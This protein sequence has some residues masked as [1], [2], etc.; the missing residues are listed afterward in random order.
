MVLEMKSIV[1]ICY[2]SGWFN[3]PIDCQAITFHQID[4]GVDKYIIETVVNSIKFH[5]QSSFGV[6]RPL[7]LTHFLMTSPSNHL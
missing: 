3:T 7:L 2:M 5:S 6:S 4:G 1:R